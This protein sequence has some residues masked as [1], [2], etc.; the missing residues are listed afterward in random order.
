M[1]SWNGEMLVYRV[2]YLGP[3]VQFDVVV[4]AFA[5]SELPSKADRTEVVETLWRKTSHFLVS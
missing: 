2:T 1:Y 4:S 5:L 3:Q